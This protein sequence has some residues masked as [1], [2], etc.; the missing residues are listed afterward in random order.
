MSIAEGILN[1]E[2]CESC[3]VFLGKPV[4]FPTQC[5]MCNPKNKPERTMYISS[6]KS[7]KKRSKK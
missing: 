5:T 7:K 3:G 6:G 2:F 4:G 1:G